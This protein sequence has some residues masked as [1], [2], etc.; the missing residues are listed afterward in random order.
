MSMKR[1]TMTCVALLVLLV[2]LAAPV[3]GQTTASLTLV[4]SNESPGYLIDRL[5][6]AG[7]GDASL[8]EVVQYLHGVVGEVIPSTFVAAL[9]ATPPGSEVKT[10]STVMGPWEFSRSTLGTSTAERATR[11]PCTRPRQ[12]A[13]LPSC[14]RPRPSTT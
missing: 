7:Y 9:A 10:A 13:S 6:A 5:V 14:R 1:F 8:Y 11:P 2:A 4:L 3:A 12:P